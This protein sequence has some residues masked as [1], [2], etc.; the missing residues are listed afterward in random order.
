MTQ[1]CAIHRNPCPASLIS[2]PRHDQIQD[3]VILAIAFY[4]LDTHLISPPCLYR[5]V[6]ILHF[7]ATHEH[8]TVCRKVYDHD[9]GA[10][11]YLHFPGKTRGIYQ[12]QYVVLNESA[13]VSS[14]PTCLPEPLFQGGEGAYPTVEL[15]KRSIYCGWDVQVCEPPPSYGNES[16]EY[17]KADKGEVDNHYK[18]RRYLKQHPYCPFFYCPLR[19]AIPLKKMIFCCGSGTSSAK[20]LP[21]GPPGSL[22]NM[23]NRRD[24]REA[25]QERPKRACHRPSSRVSAYLTP[26]LRVAEESLLAQFHGKRAT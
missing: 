20:W 16:A 5:L 17:H 12:G 24:D 8:P 26:L 10:E 23:R 22:V 6:P 13:T 4:H 1:G 19:A 3:K 9:E 14:L 21:K 18:I 25:L 7:P 15:D 2:V 11:H